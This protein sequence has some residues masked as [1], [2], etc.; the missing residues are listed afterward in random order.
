MNHTRLIHNDFS[1]F[2]YNNNYWWHKLVDRRL[3][4]LL[5]VYL[6][7]HDTTKLLGWPFPLNIYLYRAEQ[8]SSCADAIAPTGNWTKI[9]CDHIFNHFVN[10][11]TR[12]HR[13]MYIEVHDEDKDSDHTAQDRHRSR[14]LLRS[15]IIWVDRAFLDCYWMSRTCAAARFRY[16]TF[17]NLLCLGIGDEFVCEHPIVLSGLCYS[18]LW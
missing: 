4:L 3:R 8:N 10:E 15:C 6:Q 17:K 7:S 11:K 16:H 5:L 12:N 18:Q 13:Q 14:H 9:S 1:V 2:F